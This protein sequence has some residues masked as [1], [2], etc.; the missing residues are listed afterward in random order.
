MLLGFVLSEV[1]VPTIPAT[2]D[3][4]AGHR[5]KFDTCVLKCKP[6]IWAN[7]SSHGACLPQRQAEA[8]LH[9]NQRRASQA[10][11]GPAGDE[12]A[13][14]S[15]GSGHIAHIASHSTPQSVLTSCAFGQSVLSL[16][17]MNDAVKN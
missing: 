8:E 7:C 6:A 3:C 17:L 15:G 10:Q 1:H 4:V 12:T 9:P 2:W 16:F 14:E 5:S 11:V 13:A